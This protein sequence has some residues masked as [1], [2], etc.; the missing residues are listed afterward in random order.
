MKAVG[1]SNNIGLATNVASTLK[2]QSNINVRPV[3]NSAVNVRR[4][5]P[6]TMMKTNG[7][8]VLSPYKRQLKNSSIISG[9]QNA[10]YNG[11]SNKRPT[12]HSGAL[13]NSQS[14][15]GST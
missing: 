6:G 11:G 10:Y 7:N 13:P 3:D 8:A 15:S 4:S 1:A 5:T 9:G 12:I 14:A 2:A